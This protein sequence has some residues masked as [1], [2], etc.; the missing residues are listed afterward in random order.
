MAEGIETSLAAMQLFGI[1]VWSTLDAG[2]IEKFVPPAGIR[3]LIVFGDND[4]NGRGQRAAH[5]LAARLSGQ[6]DVEVKIP[7]QPD[8]DW[9]DALG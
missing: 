7:D 1:P 3:Q 5:T 9:N 6:I 8:T 2:G 4:A